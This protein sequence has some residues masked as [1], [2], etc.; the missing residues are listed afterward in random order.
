MVVL[1]LISST[2][3]TLEVDST[4][5]FPSRPAYPHGTLVD[6]TA[7]DGDNMAPLAKVTVE[8]TRFTDDIEHAIQ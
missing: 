4:T 8:G 6:Y 7:Q 5:P 1:L 3:T 2:Q